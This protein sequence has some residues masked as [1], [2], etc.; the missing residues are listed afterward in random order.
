MAPHYQR[1]Q[2]QCHGL[3]RLRQA[4]SP[5]Y[6]MSLLTSLLERKWHVTAVVQLTADWQRDNTCLSRKQDRGRD[7]SLP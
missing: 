5:E 6:A 7:W 2:I 3:H 4:C 1:A